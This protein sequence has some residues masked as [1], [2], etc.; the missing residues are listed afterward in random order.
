V[1]RKFVSYP[2][3]TSMKIIILSYEQPGMKKS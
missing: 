1:D 2:H 3:E